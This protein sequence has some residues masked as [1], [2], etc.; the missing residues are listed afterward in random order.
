MLFWCVWEGEDTRA[1]S[2]NY[3]TCSPSPVFFFS[4]SSPTFPLINPQ[5]IILPWNVHQGYGRGCPEGCGTLRSLRALIRL[6]YGDPQAVDSS[7]AD[8]YCM[9]LLKNTAA[10]IIAD[11]AIVENCIDVFQSIHCGKC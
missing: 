11:N 4:F 3:E 6:N 2:R 8:K 10:K 5:V 7:V 1:S 9:Q